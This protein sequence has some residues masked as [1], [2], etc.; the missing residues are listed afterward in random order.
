MRSLRKVK[1]ASLNIDQNIKQKLIEIL[2]ENETVYL[3]INEKF[4]RIIL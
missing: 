3:E 1:V 2:G 4:I